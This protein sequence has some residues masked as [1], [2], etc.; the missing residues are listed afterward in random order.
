MEL[1]Y[2]RL[3]MSYV[4][5]FHTFQSS[6]LSDNDMSTDSDYDDPP[7]M[8]IGARIPYHLTVLRLIFLFYFLLESFDGFTIS[9]LSKINLKK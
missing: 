9:K 4:D 5:P 3:V 1:E 8:K 7:T 2:T 6:S